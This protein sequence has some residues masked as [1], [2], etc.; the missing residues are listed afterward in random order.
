MN[1]TDWTQ[2]LTSSA[3]LRC[4]WPFL[5]DV[6]RSALWTFWAP[7]PS[8][9][10][11]LLMPLLL[12]QDELWMEALLDLTWKKIVEYMWKSVRFFSPSI[13]LVSKDSKHRSSFLKYLLEL[14]A[15]STSF[16]GL[17]C[18][19]TEAFSAWV[20]ATTT[21]VDL[22]CWRLVPLALSSPPPW[23]SWACGCCPVDDGV[24]GTGA[25]CNVWCNSNSSSVK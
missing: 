19:V 15:M 3:I 8:A 12:L 6:F 20:A 22:D 24:E 18:M 16:D 1:K 13:S 4:S 17:A 9:A 2:C 5:M 10:P 14:S 11:F 23:A 7:A 25:S 21:G